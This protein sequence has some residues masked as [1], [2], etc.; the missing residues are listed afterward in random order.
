[1]LSSVLVAAA[2]CI[3]LASFFWRC[4]LHQARSGWTWV[5]VDATPVSWRILNQDISKNNPGTGQSPFHV[6]N[7]HVVGAVLLH[8]EELLDW[9]ER[10]QRGGAPSLPDCS[11]LV[12]LQQNLLLEE[13]PCQAMRAH[14]LQL[15]DWPGVTPEWRMNAPLRRWRQQKA[16][17]PGRGAK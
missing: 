17:G 15:G 5:A 4:P 6:R 16:K 10:R 3:S 9:Q 12:S 8:P 1:M 11:F 7:P 13:M 14:S 2:L